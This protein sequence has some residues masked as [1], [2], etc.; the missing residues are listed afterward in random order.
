MVLLPLQIVVVPEIVTAVVAVTIML[1]NPILGREPV[2][3][4]PLP[5]PLPLK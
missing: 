1:S 4:Q 3:P 5:V 2:E